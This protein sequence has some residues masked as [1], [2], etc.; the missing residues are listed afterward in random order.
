M[1]LPAPH[2]YSAHRAMAMAILRDDEGMLATASQDAFGPRLGTPAKRSFSEAFVHLARAERER[3][4]QSNSHL[5]SCALA[6]PGDASNTASTNLV[7]GST[8]G[9]VYMVDTAAVSG[10]RTFESVVSSRVQAHHRGT[11]AVCRVV[12][13]T[14]SYSADAV[15]S[16]G[17]DRKLQFWK[18]QEAAGSGESSNRELVHAATTQLLP[19]SSS[20][21]AEALC[22]MAADT[23]ETSVLAGASCGHIFMLPAVHADP[24]K[25]ESVLAHSGAILDISE[26]PS[27]SSIFSTASEDGTVALWDARTLQKHSCINRF[28]ACGS[29]SV[30]S[31]QHVPIDKAFAARKVER[32]ERAAPVVHGVSDKVLGFSK[33]VSTGHPTCCCFDASGRWLTV[34]C[35][36]GT[37]RYWNLQVFVS[38]PHGYFPLFSCLF[39]LAPCALSMQLQS[40][41]GPF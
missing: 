15:V 41:C 14:P 1:I 3:T 11:N 37:L 38:R 2:T 17:G 39:I 36:D 6:P 35:S 7:L 24:S 10:T 31:P 25:H 13:K 23:R 18:V 20:S 5:V 28:H 4:R 29:A 32:I 27:D 9:D 12:G 8:L 40:A 26:H 34:G 22:L 21:P 19:Q 16:A 33:A 30:G